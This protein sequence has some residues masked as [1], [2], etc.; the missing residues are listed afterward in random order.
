MRYL[1]HEPVSLDLSYFPM[2]IG[3][4]LLGRELARDLFPLLENELGI[5]LG[6]AD[7]K[8]GAAVPDEAVG[9]LLHISPAAPLLAVERLT[10]DTSGRPVDFEYLFIRGDAYQYQFRVRHRARKPRL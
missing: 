6:V 1:K 2:D 5:A 8:I 9:R 3:E 4:R 10:Y 7:L